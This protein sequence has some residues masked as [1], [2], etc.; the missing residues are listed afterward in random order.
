MFFQGESGPPVSPSVS[1]HDTY[2]VKTLLSLY[3]HVE[4]TSSNLEFITTEIQINVK[5]FGDKCCLCKEGWLLKFLCWSIYTL[6]NK[7]TRTAHSSC[8]GCSWRVHKILYIAVKKDNILSIF[9]FWKCSSPI[10][11]TNIN[12]AVYLSIKIFVG[13]RMVNRAPELCQ[14]RDFFLL[15]RMKEIFCLC[16]WIYAYF[17]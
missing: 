17:R 16:S 1:A 3:W 6:R 15:K 8:G 11:I 9:Y 2:T 4:C 12:P 5:L 13:W 7:C 10:I 14:K